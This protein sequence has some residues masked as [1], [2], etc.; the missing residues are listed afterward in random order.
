M[1]RIIHIVNS[2]FG[3]GHNL[4]V[5]SWKIAQGLKERSDLVVLC[6]AAAPGIRPTY[7][8]RAL[9]LGRAAGRLL[10]AVNLYIARKLPNRRI[11]NFFFEASARTAL[12]KLSA[13]PIS[14]VHTWSSIPHLLSPIKK[15]NPSVLLIR[16]HTMAAS[17][18]W[19]ARALHHEDLLVYDYF[20]SPSAFVSESL[21]RAGVPANRIICIPYGVDPDEFRPRSSGA[22]HVDFRVAFSGLVGARKG[23]PTL[24]EAWKLLD[25]QGASLNLY[26]RLDPTL[27]ESLREAALHNVFVRGFVDLRSELPQNDLFVFPTK[28]EGSAKAVYEALACGLP[29]ITTHNAGS[30]VEDGVQGFIIPPDDI[31][32]LAAKIRYFYDNRQ[33]LS[34]FSSE[35]RKLGQKYSWNRYAET[36]IDCY[37]RLT[38]VVGAS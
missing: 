11:E 22:P 20:F 23:I 37:R 6:R 5:H 3:Y 10:K 35:A 34:H 8:V 15:R 25:L 19:E 29:V 1:G 27:A 4:A 32:A 17:S 14:V 13:H 16:D 31:S 38:P 28:W 24:L 7:D 9:G 33:A 2:D 12:Q 18:S 26:G 36:V 30:V 21:I